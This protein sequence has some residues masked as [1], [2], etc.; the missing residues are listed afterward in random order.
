MNALE[1]ENLVDKLADK[2]G[3]AVDNV[4]PIAQETLN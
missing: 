1:I 4:M 3:V 2:L